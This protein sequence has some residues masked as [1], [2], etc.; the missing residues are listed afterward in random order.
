[1]NAP[2]SVASTALSPQTVGEWFARLEPAPPP[3]L[4]LE[5]ERLL[6]LHSARPVADVTEVCLE[7]GE[8]LLK[9]LMSSGSTERATAL[10]LLAVD[11]LVTYAFEAASN[12]AGRIESRAANAMQRIA[13]LG[14]A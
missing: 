10:T 3:A 11:A 2:N 6:T 8:R 9:E 5:L 1:M 12:D 7:T 14:E 13:A 4:G